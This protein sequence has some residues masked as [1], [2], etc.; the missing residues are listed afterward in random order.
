VDLLLAG[1]A[2]RLTDGYAAGAPLLKRALRALRGPNRPGEEAL[3]WLHFA[4]VTAGHVWDDQT[5]HALATRHVQLAREVGAFAMLAHALNMAIA[6]HAAVGDLAMAASLADEKKAL[7]EAT[8][9]PVPSYCAPLLAAWQGRLADA[10]PIFEAID[11]EGLRRGEGLGVMIVQWARAAQPASEH[12]PEFGG[13]P[14]AVRVELIEAASRAGMPERA[15]AALQELTEPARAAGT[16]WALGIQARCRAVCT[17]DEVTAQ[18]AFQEA[19]ERL[20]RTRMRSELA[21]A[22]L[23]YGEWLR[24]QNRRV[25][26]RQQLRTAHEMFSDMGAEA[27]AQR[28]A[29]ELAISGETVRKRNF[30]APDE[31]T[32]QEAQI[33]GLVREGLSNP[34]IGARLFIS[35]RTVEW[36]VRNIFN[37]LNVTSRRQ[38]RNGSRSVGATGQTHLEIANK[39][40]ITNARRAG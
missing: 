12:P 27:F 5:W 40:T 24:R 1:L 26:G 35:R 37:K 34:E 7:T 22:H 39:A 38:L 17:D 20:G 9:I 8:G 33:V 2:T 6:M 31:L 14:W 11:Q 29:R 10:E 4:T 16:D 25:E 21:R 15:A 28:A 18:A 30:D 3:H 23:L 13:M 32:A 19:V 36:H